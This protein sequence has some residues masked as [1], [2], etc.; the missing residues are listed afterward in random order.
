M[1]TSIFFR[2][3]TQ[4][5]KSFV[6]DSKQQAINLMIET[7]LNAAQMDERHPAFL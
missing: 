6:Q 1:L 4:Q 7:E 2:R 5:F 3:T